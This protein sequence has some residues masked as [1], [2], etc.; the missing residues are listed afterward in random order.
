M[1]YM[2][3]PITS[4]NEV[5][6]GVLILF[7]RLVC[8]IDGRSSRTALITLPRLSFVLEF[9]FSRESR[10]IRQSSVAFL[11]QVLRK[12]AFG[13]FFVGSRPS[14]HYFRSVCSSVCLCRVFLSRL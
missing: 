4:V 6:V 1:A 5:Y 10:F 3:R 9:F 2:G 7:P 14:D 12:P 13:V 11:P 8:V